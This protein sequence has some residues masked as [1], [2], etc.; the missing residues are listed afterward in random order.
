M[1]LS[2]RTLR[3]ATGFA[4]VAVIATAL[5]SVSAERSTAVTPTKLSGSQFIPGNIIDDAHFFTGSAMTQ[6]QIQT[7]LSGQQR[8][9]SNS[10][11]LSVLTLATQTKAANTYC[12]KP[13]AGSSKE[14]AAAVI[15][16]VQ[17]ACGISAKVLL[18]TLQKEQGLV[19]STAPT[20]S[21]VAHAMGYLC[22][23]TAPC[24]TGA[25]NF[26]SQVY[27]AAYQ[28][29]IYRLYPNDFNFHANQ[30]A[31]I[32]LNPNAACGRQTVFIQNAATAALY[33]YTPYVPNA[34]ALANL[35]GVGDGCSAYGNRNFWVYYNSWFGSGTPPFGVVDQ[36]TVAK[37]IAT[38]S[39]WSIDPA[40]PLTPAPV[41][42]QITNPLG[43]TTTTTVS[44]NLNRTDVGKAYPYAA[45]GDGT[46]LHG[47]SVTSSQ[48]A[49]GQYTFCVTAG[50]APGSPSAAPATS[51][52][53]TSM[54]YSPSVA[55][56]TTS[57][58]AGA[59]R[60]AT[61][62]AVSKATFPAAGVPV[63][64]LASGQIYY[65][66]LSAGPAAAAQG[67][68]LLLTMQT[69]IP[70]A[71]LT[72]LSRLKPARVVIVGGPAAI[73]DNVLNAV[74]S[75]TGAPVS[76]LYGADRFL[77][78]QAIA[79]SV[80]PNA[81]TAFA[82]S[83]LNFPDALS[84]SAAAGSVKAPILLANGGL[85]TADP[86]IDRYLAASPKITTVQL[87]G[88]TTAMPAALA[89]GLQSTGK[90]VTRIAGQ[91]RFLTSNAIAA[92]YFPKT[93]NAYLTT[94]T[95][96]ADALTGSV[97]AARANAPLM[98][99]WPNCVPYYDGQTL[100]KA[101]VTSVKLLGGTASLTNDVAKLAVCR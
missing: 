91:D 51:L 33:N 67:G 44:A 23:D 60:F 76:R 97:A 43:K 27:G 57:R 14:S 90:K 100:L 50:L 42:V 31:S 9:C 69:S 35:S 34:A 72:E 73:S 37:G 95:G 17:V 99:V 19:T 82:V 98:V 54:W 56:P 32:L 29:Q 59:D 96:W 3:I 1:R 86:S 13:Y 8:G 5:V 52:G 78:S 4:A 55:A 94:G 2:D 48:T 30:T 12:T 62:V 16:K 64:Y 38:V 84:A 41:T 87:I 61:A 26:F 88:G 93:A 63:V 58:L 7:F 85:S 66:A 21:A 81:I 53:C 39:G 70:S 75:R 22:P 20:S 71:T 83:G 65:D 40:L 18:A 36:A 45:E 47:F 101:G 25:A 10:S 15:Y 77:T 28:F 11:C 92:K 89:S 6:A 74:R 80:F 24:N 68:P 46:T 79:K 49:A